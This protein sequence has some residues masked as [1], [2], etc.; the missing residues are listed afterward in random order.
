MRVVS[1]RNCV[2]KPQY[3]TQN[4]KNELWGP[5][6][7]INWSVSGI[8]ERAFIRRVVCPNL[9]ACLCKIDF[10]FTGKK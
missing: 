1:G 7:S 6:T 8:Q 10:G 9:L 5:K 3:G 2:N 4:L